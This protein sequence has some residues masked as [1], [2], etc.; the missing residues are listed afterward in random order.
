MSGVS[1][2]WIDEL[3][4]HESIFRR[5]EGERY[6]KKIRLPILKRLVDSIKIDADLSHL[7]Q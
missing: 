4:G 1:S 2:N 7:R 5:S 3:I 6:T